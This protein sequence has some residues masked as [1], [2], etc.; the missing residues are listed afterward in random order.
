MLTPCTKP[1]MHR[2]EA[3]G[4][5]DPS[6]PTKPRLASVAVQKSGAGAVQLDAL[7]ADDE[8]GHLGAILAAHKHLHQQQLLNL[9]LTI[10]QHGWVAT[11]LMSCLG[12]IRDGAFCMMKVPVNADL[13]TTIILETLSCTCTAGSYQAEGACLLGLQL[14][15]L[16]ITLQ[17]RLFDHAGLGAGV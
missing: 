17:L 9:A 16:D 3:A 14:L 8:H 13:Q 2:Y 6:L 12:P 11:T 1:H 15:E 5:Y 7:L 10:P 4:L